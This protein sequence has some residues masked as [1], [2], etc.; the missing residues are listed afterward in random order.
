MTSGKQNGLVNWLLHKRG[1][2]VITKRKKKIEDG[3]RV[4]E[5]RRIRWTLEEVSGW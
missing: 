5:G 2:S 3:K 4:E 1:M